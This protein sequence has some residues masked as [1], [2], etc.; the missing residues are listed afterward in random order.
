MISPILQLLEKLLR[1]L[2]VGGI[3]ALF[4]PTIED[5]Q[6]L[7]SFFFHALL[8]EQ[9]TQAHRRPE[10]QELRTLAASYLDRLAKAGVRLLLA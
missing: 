5:G 9:A 1:F 3:K 6:H 2:Q 8:F 10:L 7:M 4:E